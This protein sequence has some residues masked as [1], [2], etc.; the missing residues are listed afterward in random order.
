MICVARAPLDWRATIWAVIDSTQG[1]ARSIKII[2]AQVRSL[3]DRCHAPAKESLSK[4]DEIV[5]AHWLKRSG[6]RRRLR[7]SLLLG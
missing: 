4:L 5:G 1:G 6:R 7:N 2:L 3:T